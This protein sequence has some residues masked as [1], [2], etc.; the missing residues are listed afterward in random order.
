MD[1][2]EIASAEGFPAAAAMWGLLGAGLLTIGLTQHNPHCSVAAVAPLVLAWGLF[3]FR[4]PKIA[5]R[6]EHEALVLTVP[7]ATIPYDAIESLTRGGRQQE[8]E[9]TFRNRPIGLVHSAGVLTIPAKLNMPIDDVYRILVG[10]TVTS[11]S[12]EVHSDM[13]EHLAKE[14][15]T[16]GED[17]VWTFRA[18]NDNIGRPGNPRQL[19]C[20]ALLALAAVF[21]VVAPFVCFDPIKSPERHVWI[22]FGVMLGLVS[23]IGVLTAA[24]SSRLIA[25]AVPRWRESSMVIS[26]SGLAM[27]QG[28]MRGHMRWDELRDVRLGKNKSGSFVVVDQTLLPALQLEVAG[29]TIQMFDIYDRPLP[30]IT[31]IVRQ[32]WRQPVA[33]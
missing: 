29:A 17:R 7:D 32:L 4:P 15:E 2:L 10:K 26:P 31:R 27:L 9:Q 28:N 12:R 24:K 8:P 25:K 3:F 1:Q 33:K 13:K 16:F 5:G 22:G 30:A 14:I 6:L 18:R 20:F 23:L 19:R 11:G 21:W